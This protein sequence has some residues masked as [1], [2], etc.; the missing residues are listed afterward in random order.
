M[1]KHNELAT[2]ASEIPASLRPADTFV[3]RH[4]GSA[5]AEVRQ[6]LATIGADSLDTLVGE[7]VPDSI[8]L[9]ERFS[10]SWLPEDRPLGESETLGV[11][12]DIAGKNR[13]F[14]S[15]LGMG[16]YDCLVPGVIQRNILE[17][18]G[19][20]TQYTPY[21]AEISQG[22]LEAS[23]QLPDD[24]R[25]PDR[26]ADGQRVA[27]RRGDRRGRGH[28]HVRRVWRTAT[29][30]FVSDD[31]HP[32]TIAVVKTRAG[33]IGVEV[34]VANVDDPTS[35]DLQGVFGVLVQYP[36]TDGRIRDWSGLIE[37]AHAGGGPGGRWRPTC[38]R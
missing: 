24:D 7:T 6:M 17:N 22:R 18:P 15:Y 10:L 2:I 33:A 1:A 27:A 21:Q 12:R 16:Y 38:W 9:R 13:I 36:A 8:R 14:R 3:R 4:L 5:D 26:P 30:F 37:R 28:A 34:R 20:Y 25:R 29:S 11:L 23:A 35:C 19:W 32:Q 31:C